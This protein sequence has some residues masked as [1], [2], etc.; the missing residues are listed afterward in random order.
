MPPYLRLCLQT[1]ERHLRDWQIVVLD[2]TNFGD[3][4][5][6]GLFELDALR[7]L[8]L[9]VQKEAMMVGSLK[10]RG[11]VFLDADTLA[12]KDIRPLLAELQHSEA[13]I[14]GY[15]LAFMAARLGA[16][17]ALGGPHPA[18]P[19]PSSEPRPRAE[20]RSLGLSGQRHPLGAVGREG[21]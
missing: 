18:A 1:W 12:F 6:P 9:Q 14:Y 2:H 13:L 10:E 20:Q 4:F 21:H 17:G 15:H 7:R 11:G 8:P 19:E 3:W 16:V 5:D